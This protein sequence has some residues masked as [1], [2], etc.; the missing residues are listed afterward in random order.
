MVNG[1]R[2]RSRWG[3]GWYLFLI[4]LFLLGLFVGIR[5]SHRVA[6]GR[7]GEQPPGQTE[8]PAE[9]PAPSAPPG[10]TPSE[11]P[12]SAS[13]ALPPESPSEPPATGSAQP[14]PEPP[15]ETP[16]A[17]PPTLAQE[18]LEG[19]TL[20]EKVYQMFMVFPS[21]ITGVK[22]VTQAG[23]MTRAA[24]ERFPVGGLLYDTT[25]MENREQVREMLENT[26]QYSRIPPLLACDEEG[27]RVAR[28]MNRVGTTQVGPM[29][30]Y[31]HLGTEAARA[32]ARTIAGDMVS[33]GFNTDLA[34]VADVWSNPENTAIGDRAY[35]DD[36]LQAAELIP[37]AVEGFHEGGTACVLKHFPGHGDTTTDSH[38]GAAYVNKTLDQ[39]R[40]EELLPFRAGIGA[41][42]DMVM[43]GHLT[44]PEVDSEPAPFSYR[45]VT[46]LLREELGFSGV[47]MT[48]SLEMGAVSGRW[49][50]GEMAVKAVE[51]GVDILLCP[52]DLE[53]AADALTGAVERGEISQERIDESVL[54]ILNMKELRG[55]L[56]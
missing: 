36:F 16:P 5:V 1:K 8:S 55:I 20:R 22:K 3:R 47:V 23:E 32:N 2:R 52:L 18:T 53:E 4:A 7:G 33:C 45:L 44:V 40:R 38:N 21:D 37:A 35:S 39:L 31:K 17:K 19:M 10:G 49:T 51:A 27:G 56:R 11:A 34:P 48:D 30:S 41:G 12:A 6:G 42:A 15:A 29:L 14:S 46:G 26:R 28:L 25:N 13:T 50:S 9:T 54:R 24:L 43:L